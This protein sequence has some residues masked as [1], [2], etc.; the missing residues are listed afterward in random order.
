MSRWVL[1]T[2]D[3]C[4]PENTP[5]VSS[6]DEL[7]EDK[8]HR[9]MESQ[10]RR[11]PSPAATRASTTSFLRGTMKL[12][13]SVLYSHIMMGE[14]EPQEFLPAILLDA[15]DDSVELQIIISGATRRC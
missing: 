11:R 12:S 1:V 9:R 5:L 15:C 10:G 7:A 4:P 13:E 2:R 3:Q 14:P 8:A 6:V